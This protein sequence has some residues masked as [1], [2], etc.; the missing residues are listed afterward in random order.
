MDYLDGTAEFFLTNGKALAFYALAAFALVA[1]LFVITLRNAVHCAVFLVTTFI[2]VAG[3]YITLKAEFIAAVQ[4]LVYAGGIMVLFVFAIL[5]VNIAEMK[6]IRSF[7]KQWLISVIGV[8]AL[9]AFAIKMF[10]TVDLDLVAAVSEGSAGGNMETVAL[11]LYR[12][13]LFPFEIASVLLLVAMIGAIIMTKKD[14]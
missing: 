5:L 7:H 4:I 6:K 9:A 12:Q 1:G 8:V 3:I 10:L 14:A 11:S 13:Y 2:A